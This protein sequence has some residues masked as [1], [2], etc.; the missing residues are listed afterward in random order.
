LRDLLTYLGIV[1]IVVLTAALAAPFLIDFDAFRSRIAE[2]ISV[3]SGAQATLNGPISLRLLPVP[4]FSAQDFQLSGDFGSIHAQK[5]FF[6]LSLPGLIGGRLQFSRARLDDC[7]ILIETQMLRAHE[8]LPSTQWDNLLLHRAKLTFLRGGEP[9]L[10]LENLELAAQ[11]PSPDGPFQGRGSLSLAGEKVAFSFASDLMAKGL[12]PLKASLIRPGEAGQLDLDGI[13][14]LA[15]APLFEGQ[16]KAEGKAEAGPWQA[17]AAFSASFERAEARGFAATLG[18]GARANKITGGGR[19]EAGLRKISF[20]L[21]SA[22]LDASW[23]ELFSAP[24]RAATS[25]AAPL[26]LH[27]AVGALNWRGADWTEVDFSLGNAGPI[28]GRAQGPGG[29]KLD[30][31]ATPDGVGWRG[32]GRF[33]SED[34]PAFAAAVPQVAALAGTN[35]RSVEIGGDFT[36][37]PEEWRLTGGQLVLDRAHLAGNL[38]FSP[39]KPG[40]RALLAARLA[41]PALD[42]DAAPD[43]GS[44]LLGGVDLDLSLEAQ[45][46]K[47]ARDGRN[48]GQSG[49]IQMHF[50]RDG[51]AA[52]L[53]KLDLQDIGGANLQVS[54]AWRDNSGGLDFSGVGGE[55]RLKAAD[56]SELARVLARLFPGA[57][58]KFLAGRAKL[59]SPAELFA[60]GGGDRSFEVKGT[61][62]GTRIAAALAPRASEKFAASFDLASPDG[63]ILLNQLGASLL[64]APKLGSARFSAHAQSRL[65]PSEKLDVVASADLAGLH[66]DF[67][68]FAKDLLRSLAIEG[69]LTIAGDAAK[70]MGVFSSP[71]QLP[72]P[73]RFSA[74]FQAG[75]GA[76]ALRNLAGSWGEEQIAGNLSLGA[77]GISGDLSCNRLS[78][79][80]LATLLLGPPAPAK[81]GALW[82][83][84]SFAPLAVDPPSAKL[85]LETP[86]LQPFGAKARFE[87][88]SGPGLLSVAGARVELA[89]GILRGGLELRREGGRVTLSGEAEAENIALENPGFSATMDGRLHFAGEGASAAALIGSMAGNGGARAK[90]LVVSSASAEAPDR[91]L[92]ASEENEAP[93]DVAVVSKNL[94]DFF[95]RAPFRLAEADFFVRL[96]GG[97]L[98]LVRD[99]NAEPG[100]EFF[101]DLSDASMALALSLVAGQ[102]PEGWTAPLP[103]AGVIWE[104]AWRDRTWQEPTRRLDASDFINAV[105]A[106]A[107]EREQAR[108]EGLRRQDRER[109]RALAPGQ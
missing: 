86:D 1:L 69:D 98:S 73:A 105:A 39:D 33:K 34:F 78:V 107:L 65:A 97:R 55:A 54:G 44:A 93:F 82:S 59:L 5:A 83:S 77:L 99:K 75:E 42:I 11:A 88:T 66:G 4:R 48:M 41:A 24:L 15:A 109:L 21:A 71:P 2:E 18:E 100:L 30:F 13:L 76:A 20:D 31:S 38:R 8:S 79:P 35:F 94:D 27:F 90:N 68:G 3:A 7:E 45:T 64:P 62:G 92:A 63:G 17:K 50:L 101:F 46:V 16:A 9:A 36:V 22:Q 12:L 70:L 28:K 80:A 10:R 53:E 49:R 43:L 57:A 26:D 95:A 106:R 96:A 91:A 58:T 67:H 25:S 6:E 108:I 102:K 52:R 29:S 87:L 81:A 40:R 60:R 89:G 85:S 74:L 72:V 19:Y 23:A 104:G 103:R 32:N 47:L 37:S 51:A 61:L 84:L 14:N 56:F